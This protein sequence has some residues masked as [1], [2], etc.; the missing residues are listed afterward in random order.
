MG[1]I[2]LR[3]P[4]HTWELRLYLGRDEEGR[5]KHKYATFV[6]GKRDAERELARLSLQF[7]SK[8]LLSS[9]ENTL[10]GS[11]TTFNDAILAWQKNGWQDL[12]PKTVKDYEGIFRLYIKDRVG[13]K[14][15][16]TTGVFELE[17]YFRSL[18]E[19]GLGTSG[20]RQVRAILHKA[21]RLAGKWSGGTIPN[22]VSQA[23]LPKPR[24]TPVPVRAPLLREV[25]TILE[26]A[27]KESD[28]R[29]AVFIRV[30]AATGVRRGEGLALR[31]SDIAFDSGEITIDESVIKGTGSLIVKSPK[32]PVSVR[33]VTA[34][35]G[36]IR[37]IERLR[38]V[39]LLLAQSCGHSLDSSAFVFSFDPDGSNPPHPDT[40]S[41]GF[42][43]IVKQAGLPSDI[44]L[45]SLRH[46]QA[47]VID[48]I[49]S[50][51]QKQARLGWSTS[52]MA[53]HY[54]DPISDE[55]KK[56]ADEVGR[57]LDS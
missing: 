8:P 9:D 42:K 4:P 39:Q 36:T 12:S 24:T 3:T 7:E 17:A 46:F 31:W 1:S 48:P 44:H 5:V 11:K 19:A 13:P 15:I 40:V 33:T 20:I 10:W 50:E 6:G 23:D 28:I 30:L 2:R 18:S 25:R 35:Q 54:T 38:D 49:V 21:T 53:R 43:K 52:H 32:T 27:V 56:I 57:L 22:P 16:S 55:D 45:H 14:R 47:T 41:H 29:I 34:D 51:R 37:A 26:A